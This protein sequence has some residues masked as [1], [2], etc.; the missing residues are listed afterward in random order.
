[1]RTQADRLGER[2]PLCHFFRTQRYGKMRAMAKKKKKTRFDVTKAVKAASRA[3][4]GVV[5]ATKRVPMKKE[6]G[7]KH[8]PTLAKL[9]D[10]DGSVR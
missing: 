4:I 6:A 8:K 10:D 7:Q 5:P 3:N 2:I 9:L 1:V